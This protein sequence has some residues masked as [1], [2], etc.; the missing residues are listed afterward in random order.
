MRF[1]SSLR[2]ENCRNPASDVLIS[3]KIAFRLTDKL[4][5]ISKESRYF[6]EKLDN[7]KRDKYYSK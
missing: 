6:F 1:L 2:E 4:S 7:E 5:S 3:R